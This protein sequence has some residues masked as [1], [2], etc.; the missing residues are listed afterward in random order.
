MK[1]TKSIIALTLAL[2]MCLSLFAGCGAKE[3]AAPASTAPEPESDLAYIT[4][5]GKM[6]IGY[7]VYEPMNYTDADGKFTGFDTEFAEAVCEKLGVEPDFVEIIWDT[8]ET[9][10]AA[11]TI[12]CIWNGLTINADRKAAMSIS[13]PYVK[14]AQVIVV[15]A[16]SGITSTADLVGKTVVAE[17]ASAGELQIIGDDETEPEANLAQATYISMAKQTDCLL[18]VKAGT[19]DAAVLDWTLAK[20]MIGEGTDYSDLVMIM[21]L[22]LATEEYGIAF[23]QGSDVTAKVNEIIAQLVADGTL[24][25]LAEKYGLSLAPAIAG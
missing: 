13:D 3:S 21:D 9:E 24:P 15:H 14:N 5:N 10:L 16:D 17:V 7:T 25:A 23:R 19:A 11:K 12:D 2:V 20:S 22:E 8:K 18:E 6:I 1:K 4:G